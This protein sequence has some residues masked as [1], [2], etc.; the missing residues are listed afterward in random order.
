M[1]HLRKSILTLLALTLFGGAGAWAQGPTTVFEVDFSSYATTGLMR[2]GN[3]STIYPA[4]IKIHDNLVT[5]NTYKLSSYNYSDNNY[6]SIK[7]ETGSFQTGDTLLIAMCYNNSSE[8]TAAADIYAA[9]GTTLLFTTA[10][11]I[12]GRN[13]SG[14]PV[15]EK[16]VLEQDADS[17]LIGGSSSNTSITFVTTLKVLRPA[18]AQEIELTKSGAN[19]WSLGQTPGY[20][21]ELQV[22]YYQKYALKNIPEGWTVMV[23]GVAQTKPYQGDSLLITETDSVTL[24]PDNPLRVKS[25][26]LEE[27]GPAVQTV[28][29][30]GIELQIAEGDT[31]ADIIARNPGVIRDEDDWI[32]SNL[33]ILIMGDDE[34]YTSDTYN[35]SANYRWQSI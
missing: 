25:V 8:K 32:A 10:P 6:L 17:L 15:V 1:K 29:I 34:V 20:D 23:N 12:N 3:S 24:I 19:Q 14:D 13:E 9:N 30:E 16:F 22:E 33:G 31:W 2:I 4:T 27:D 28:N 26:T 5:I 35:P 21:L 18:G 7:P 11:G